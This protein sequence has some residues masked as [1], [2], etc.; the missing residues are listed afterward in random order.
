[1][2]FTDTVKREYN[3]KA[4]M[5]NLSHNL[6]NVN[7]H[8]LNRIEQNEGCVKCITLYPLAYAEAAYEIL[9]QT[10]PI[11]AIPEVFCVKNGQDS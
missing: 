6:L 11:F 4:W 2:C 5:I 1:M 7:K 9:L 8:L 3:S 10:V